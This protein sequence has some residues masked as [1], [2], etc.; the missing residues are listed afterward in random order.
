MN[1]ND[2]MAEAQRYPP[3]SLEHAGRSRALECAE[4]CRGL[5]SFNSS[6]IRFTPQ[7]MRYCSPCD[8]EYREPERQLWTPSSA[9]IRHPSVTTGKHISP[10]RVSAPV[11]I[12]CTHCG[13]QVEERHFWAAAPTRHASTRRDFQSTELFPTPQPTTAASVFCE[14]NASH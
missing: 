8:S 14:T 4:R 5:M 9:P 1:L 12:S 10:S 3:S 2:L 13:L 6:M 11:F 7:N